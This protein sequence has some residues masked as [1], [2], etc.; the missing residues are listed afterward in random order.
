MQ[1]HLGDASIS[2]DK[3]CSLS[4][5]GEGGGH[6]HKGNLCCFLVGILLSVQNNLYTIM[7]YFGVAYTDPL[8]F[9][10]FPSLKEN[11]AHYSLSE[12]IFRCYTWMRIFWEKNV[13]SWRAS[14]VGAVS[15]WDF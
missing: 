6:L 11:N 2:G 9:I 5:V 10:Y 12:T 3:C 15:N 7:V 4:G 1:T 14:D 13:P 8:Y